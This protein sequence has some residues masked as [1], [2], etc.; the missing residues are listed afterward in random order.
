MV[1]KFA[2]AF[3]SVLLL[4]GC[5]EEPPSRAERAR[6][7]ANK[8]YERNIASVLGTALGKMY[9][10]SRIGHMSTFICMNGSYIDYPALRT[11]KKTPADLCN[12]VA[13]QLEAE[14]FNARCYD[15]AACTI[16]LDFNWKEK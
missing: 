5:P 16:M 13:K 2:L 6:Q 1:K 12:D 14:G 4:A 11:A 9:D 10:D 8:A 3:T 15:H 7:E